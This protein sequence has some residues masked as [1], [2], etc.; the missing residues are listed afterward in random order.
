M[1]QLN[2]NIDSEIMTLQEKMMQFRN[3]FNMLYKQVQ[4]EQQKVKG[5]EEELEM[6]KKEKIKK[7]V[8]ELAEI[9]EAGE[10]VEN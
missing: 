10:N 2:F 9:D 8:N 6:L 3:A 7:A 4:I 5:L 1:P